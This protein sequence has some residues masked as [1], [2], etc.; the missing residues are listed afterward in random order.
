[1][2]PERE[3]VLRYRRDD[4]DTCTGTMAV[5][6]LPIGDETIIHR[7]QC[8][9]F[10]R[11]FAKVANNLNEHRLERTV[12]QRTDRDGLLPVLLEK[13]TTQLLR[14]DPVEALRVLNWGSTTSNVVDLT[15]VRA[16]KEAQANRTPL[17]RAGHDTLADS[18]GDTVYCRV[19]A[20][21]G[22]ECPFCGLTGHF[23]KPMFV[24]SRCKRTATCAVVPSGE[25]ALFSVDELL[26]K[27]VVRLYLPRGWNPSR[28]WIGKEVLRVLYEDWLNE[29]ENRKS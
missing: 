2:E 17:F 13:D 10:N 15:A 21:G 18:L 9:T 27:D 1:M 24:C 29:K 7:F 22:I 4:G 26:Q 8:Y 25:W 11:M 5:R 19:R 6:E 28:G 3:L 23:E 12:I 16:K 20:E 14:T